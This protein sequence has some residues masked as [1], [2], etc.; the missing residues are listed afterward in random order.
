MMSSW[1]Q[2]MNPRRNAISSG[3]AT[4]IS[5]PRLERL[6]EAWRIDLRFERSPVKLR[7]TASRPFDVKSTGRQIACLQLVISSP[8]A[9]GLTREAWRT[10]S[11]PKKYRPMTAQFE[12]EFLWLVVDTHRLVIA[13]GE[14]RAFG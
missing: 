9:G 3:H 13:V 10:I 11:L 6:H 14:E 1:S 12:P 5:L 7:K 2:L 8:R 4:F